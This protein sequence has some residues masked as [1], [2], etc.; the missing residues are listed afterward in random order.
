MA[1]RQHALDL[2]DTVGKF[3][4][5]EVE[6]QCRVLGLWPAMGT[7]EA[8][9]GPLA[10]PVYAATVILRDDADLPGL[11]DSK[12]LTAEAREAL[13]PLI[14]RASLAWAVVAASE[15]D[16]DRLNILGAS[17][18]AMRRATEQVCAALR[19]QGLDLPTVLLVDGNQLVPGLG[20]LQQR[21]VVSGD[22]RS[23]AIAAASVLAKVARDQHMLEQDV[24]HPGYGFAEH[25]GY[26]T[27]KH[28][29]ALRELG[30]CPIH[31]LSFAPV[32]AAVRLRE[33]Q[34]PVAGRLL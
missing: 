26:G 11:D 5:G 23:R 12:K 28:L 33:G 16:I 18:S 27:P 22:A 14:H 29:K 21:T 4:L 15:A 20:A 2:P 8:G 19:S 30:P 10:G 7:D 25:K 3:V 13:V 1:R 24:R 17:L 34:M 31:R 32:A 6:A 9:R